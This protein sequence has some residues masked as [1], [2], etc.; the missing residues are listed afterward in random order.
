MQDRIINVPFASFQRKALYKTLWVNRLWSFNFL[1]YITELHNSE[2]LIV[3]I[4]LSNEILKCPI[5]TF[6]TLDYFTNSPL[7]FPMSANS[8]S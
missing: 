1:N 5:M 3:Q 6:I 7:L 2:T 8:F 4:P